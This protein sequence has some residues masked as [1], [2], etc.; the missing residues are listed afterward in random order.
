MRI[1]KDL[2]ESAGAYTNCGQ[3]IKFLEL[4][5]NGVELTE[6]TAL[7]ALD[8]GMNVLW[9]TRLLPDREQVRLSLAWA[10]RVQHFTKG[11]HEQ[12]KMLV[13]ALLKIEGNL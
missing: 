6:E 10:R 7:V 3:M 4:Y 8:D 12:V 5:P 9:L 13:K 11:R 1:T 2:L